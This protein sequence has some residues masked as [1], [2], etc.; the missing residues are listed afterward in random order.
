MN[1]PQPIA[2]PTTLEAEV[3]Q[4]RQ[5]ANCGE[6]M[7]VV[8]ALDPLLV[9]YPDNRDL[10]LLRAH[11]LRFVGQIDAALATLDRL[12]VTQPRFSLMHQERGLC[13]VARKDAPAAIEALLHAVNLN[14]ALPLSWRM[15]AGVYRLIGDEAQAAIAQAHVETLGALPSPIVAATSLFLDGDLVPA[16]AMIRAW[17]L[18]NGDHPEAMRLLAKIGMARDVLDD[19]ETLLEAVVR[20]VPDHRAARYD[21]AQCL[22]QRHKYVAARGEAERLLALDPANI[23]YRAVAAT[24]AV[25]LGDHHRAI[26][27]YRAMR[28]D[29]PAAPDIHLWLGHA[30]K[31]VGCVPEAVEAYRE[32]ARLRP[33]FG[34]A[35]WSL[36]NLKLYSFDEAMIAA[37]RSA[38]EAPGTALEDRI[39]I[40]FALGKA[41]EDRGDAATSWRYYEAGNALKRSESRYRPEIIET[42][43]RLQ[44][45]VCTTGF[46]AAREGWGAADRDPIF[47]LG[48]PR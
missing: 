20:M 25:G 37:M 45:A 24:C 16:E 6:H 5:R 30:L 42:N 13:H 44:R 19:A 36:A 18:A 29:V 3:A 27:L 12:A 41:F 26:E 11:C 39:H 14:P 1:S 35:Y 10:L 8:A 33:D 15:L 31:T 47:V 7:V 21:Y 17:L 23:D 34:D 28:A 22:V 2:P 46:F 48:L 40:R 38:E 43:T 9:G 32:A 4:L